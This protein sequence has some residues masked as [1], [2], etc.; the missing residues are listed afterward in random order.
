MSSIKWGVIE[1]FY[2][3]IKKYIRI[4]IIIFNQYNAGLRFL[5]MWLREYYKRLLCSKFALKILL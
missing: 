1:F 2:Y 4:D 3:Y 5:L